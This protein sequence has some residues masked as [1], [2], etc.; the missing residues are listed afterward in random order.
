M[1]IKS[2]KF[3]IWKK[4]F[5]NPMIEKC[6]WFYYYLTFSGNSVFLYS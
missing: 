3:Q 6:K 2:Q 5:I 4:G 1:D